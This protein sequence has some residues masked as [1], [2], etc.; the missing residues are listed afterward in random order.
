MNPEIRQ[1]VIEMIMT[2]VDLAVFMRDKGKD[3]ETIKFTITNAI[4][5]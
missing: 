2:A 1:E 4:G 3:I 5:G